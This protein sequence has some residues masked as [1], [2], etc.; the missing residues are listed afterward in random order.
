MW[1]VSKVL[2]R[3]VLGSI[4]ETS[5]VLMIRW[6]FQNLRENQIFLYQRLCWKSI[7]FFQ[8]IWLHSF[9]IT[10]FLFPFKFGSLLFKHSGNRRCV[11]SFHS[12]VSTKKNNTVNTACYNF[13]RY[14]VRD[15]FR[16]KWN[17]RDGIFLWKQLKLLFAKK[18]LHC[19][20]ST[21]F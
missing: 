3:S 19:R 10:F 6:I 21:G 7:I 18:N 16:T 11:N 15:V 9:P 1:C 17:M 13:G 5:K 4:V 8:D 14:I 12:L 20:C 2:I